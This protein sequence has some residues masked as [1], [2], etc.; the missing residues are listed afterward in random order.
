[1]TKLVRVPEVEQMTDE[2]VCSHLG[3]R[4]HEDI[5]LDFTP[6]PDRAA[7]GEPRRLNARIV[8]DTYHARLHA[9]RSDHDHEHVHVEVK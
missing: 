1:M 6:E 4:H 5:S 9:T 8:W 2:A 3:L 7:A